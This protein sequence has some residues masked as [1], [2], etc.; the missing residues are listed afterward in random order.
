MNRRHRLRGRS[1]FAALRSFG[2]DVRRGALR[3]RVVAN[4]TPESRCAFAVTGAPSAVQRNRVRRQLRHMSRPLAE[5]T[6]GLDVLASV[7]RTWGDRPVAERADELRQA[8]AT[9]AR[10]LLDAAVPS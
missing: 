8:W 7:N 5:A 2:I 6:P 9:A 3:L 4:A 10:R 1:R